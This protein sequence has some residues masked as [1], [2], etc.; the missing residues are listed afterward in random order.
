MALWSRFGPVLLDGRLQD[1]ERH[2][3]ETFQ[4]GTEGGQPDAT[5]N[6]A[7]LRFMLR[8][9]QGRLDEMHGAITELAELAG[10]VA[11]GVWALPAL[12]HCE[13]GRPQAAREVFAPIVARGYDLPEDAVHLGLSQLAAEVVH[14]L[15]DRAGAAALV[16]RLAPYPELFS[17]LAGLS[18]GCTGYFLGLLETTLG[19]ID[20][21][22]AHFADVSVVY[23]RVG[24]PAHLGRAQVAWAKALVARHAPGDAEQAQ[25]LLTAAETAAREHGFV[26]VQRR[27]AAVLAQ[28]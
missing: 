25:A 26:S 9:E 23:E 1:A 21:A 27:A 13:C 10:P 14:Q 6:D 22:I 24:A 20:K 28:S 15:D 5:V 11:P 16:D 3:E 12:L 2:A 8:F 4:V 17:A 7:I 18:I 19:H